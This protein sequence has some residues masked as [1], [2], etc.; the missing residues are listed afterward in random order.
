[1]QQASVKIVMMTEGLNSGKVD[2]RVTRTRRMLQDA[3][4]TL[5]A[6]KDFDKISIQ[7]IAEASTLNRA[8]FY[9]HYPDKSALLECLVGTRFRELITRRG[10]RFTGCAGALKTI[11]TGV[12]DYLMEMP[13]ADAP[14]SSGKPLETAIVAV[15]RGMI[16]EG[17][18][19][20][21]PA[22]EVSPELLASTA[23]WAIYGAAKE[24]ACTPNRMPVPQ[25]AGIIEAMV[26]PIFALADQPHSQPD[27]KI[28]GSNSP[29]S[30]DRVS[31][32]P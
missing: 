9:D 22:G 24:W 20:H 30:A 31:Q 16:L 10:I 4:A 29:Q 26:A 17:L 12:C 32:Q 2:P 18:S 28:V 15:V 7:D 5:L 8:T 1:M 23:A 25:M 14:S 27:S 3:L 13:S 19:Q 21:S 11:A 6:E